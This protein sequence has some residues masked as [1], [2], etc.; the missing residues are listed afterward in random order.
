MTSSS[1]ISSAIPALPN[2]VLENI[3]FPN[4]SLPELGVC[5]SVCKVWRELA[6]KHLCAFSHEKAFGPKEWYTYFGAY[7]R[8]VPRLPSN[9]AEVL[10]SP[11]PFWPERQVHETHVLV[12]IPETVSGQ[13]LNLNTL[14]ELAKKLIQGFT[15]QYKFF[16]IDDYTDPPPNKSYWVLLTRDLIK[17]SRNKTF[18]EEHAVLAYYNQN[19]KNVYEI[20]SVLDATVCNFMEYIRCGTWL[21]GENPSTYT[22]C[23]EKYDANWN[24]VIGGGSESGLYVF[25]SYSAQENRGIAAL[26]KFDPVDKPLWQ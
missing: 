26:R 19:T 9:I 15:A 13:P 2:V 3:I 14:G 23:Q 25:I 10:N 22:W 17:N 12:L 20:A 18:E 11:C 16:N 21:Y 8:N 4:L 5:S 24:F 6:K 7:L 1:T